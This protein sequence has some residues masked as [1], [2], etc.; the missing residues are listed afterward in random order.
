MSQKGN[1]RG[2]LN[3]HTL[4][5]TMIFP[6]HATLCNLCIRNSVVKHPTNHSASENIAL[7]V[8]IIWVVTSC[9]HADGY[10]RFGGTYRFHL[11]DETYKSR[12]AWRHNPHDRMLHSGHSE[13]LS[14]YI[15]TST[16]LP[17]KI[18]CLTA[19]NTTSFTIK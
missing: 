15:V 10:Q 5:Y 11:Q 13:N 19:L 18:P 14:S 8:V 6:F 12:S 4:K 17:Y 9:I 7:Y 3:L 16:Y 2:L 1:D